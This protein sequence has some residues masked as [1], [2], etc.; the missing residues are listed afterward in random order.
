MSRKP[1]IS[2]VQK[3]DF[4]NTEKFLK[5]IRKL[6]NLGL[7][8][9]YGKEGVEALKLATPVATGKTAESW[10]YKIQNDKGRVTISWSNRN[11]VDGVNIAIILQYGH[12]L[13]QGGYV[14]GRDYIN[15]AMR[16]LFDKMADEVWDYVIAKR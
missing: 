2:F 7:F 16:P 14:A 6:Q 3:G 4:K 8:D 5:R 10:S 9:K 12:G 1:V 11:V 15:P 13:R